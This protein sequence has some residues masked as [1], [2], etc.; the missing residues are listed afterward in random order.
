MTKLL[1]I[2]NDAKTVKGE[3]H[4]FLTAIMYLAP[5]K[6]AGYLVC[7]AAELAGCWQTC[8]N[9]AGRGG[10]AKGTFNPHGIE[11][12]DNSVQRARIWR[13]RLWMEQRDIFYDMLYG[14]L[15]A[16]IAQAKLRGLTP[17]VRLNGTS[18][19]QW[20]REVYSGSTVFSTFPELT[21]YDYTKLPGRLGRPLPPNYHLTLSYS[22]A[23]P[24][25]AKQ[26]LK[27]HEHGASLAVVVRDD[28]LKARWLEQGAVDF[29][30]HDLR[31]LDPP[32][33][34]GVLKAK[35]SARHETNGFVLTE[36]NSNGASIG[37]QQGL[38]SD[39]VPRRDPVARLRRE[40]AAERAA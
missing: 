20:E 21:F 29:D 16:F 11:L 15:F 6:A 23:S 26:C 3:K 13:T 12:P 27:A 7:P 34:I 28:K 37:L 1:S 4:G 14:E 8:L 10:M 35:G 31:F 38:R 25:Y 39:R 40:N 32:G 9:T 33:T 2:S 36:E 19:I 17:V 30:E 22:E 5:Y 24:L 18:D